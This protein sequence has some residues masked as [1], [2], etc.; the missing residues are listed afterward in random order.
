MPSLGRADVSQSPRAHRNH[1]P[2]SVACLIQGNKEIGRHQGFREILVQRDFHLILY[3]FAGLL[4]KQSLVNKC[5]TMV[6]FHCMEHFKRR[7]VSRGDL[8]P[9]RR[10][11]HARR[12]ARDAHRE[13]RCPVAG[14][15]KL[16]LQ[17]RV[18]GAFF[19]DER[20]HGILRFCLR[21]PPKEK[22]WGL[23]VPIPL[24][25]Y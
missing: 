18:F 9:N 19:S 7:V 23:G 5:M 15:K 21:Y 14:P 24:V 11:R 25:V 6:N 2:S 13:G 4:A 12:R 1:H 8:A 17:A 10:V 3:W 20:Q 22:N 16:M